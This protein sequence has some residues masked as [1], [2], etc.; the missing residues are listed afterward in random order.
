MH[1]I[2]YIKK[3][4]AIS[5]VSKI[6]YR[7][8]CIKCYECQRHRR[9]CLWV[10]ATLHTEYCYSFTQV[11]GVKYYVLYS[12]HR[13]SHSSKGGRLFIWKAFCLVGLALHHQSVRGGSFVSFLGLVKLKGW[14]QAR[15]TAN[16][17]FLKLRGHSATWQFLYILW[18]QSYILH[19]LNNLPA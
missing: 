14:L 1:S 8:Q 13:A 12:V 5:K 10:Y 18:E 16:P 17:Q 19:T 7:F 3:I 11:K 6:Y 2:V 9:W 4:K 15:H